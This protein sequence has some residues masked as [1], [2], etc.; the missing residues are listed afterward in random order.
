M[1]RTDAT[2]FVGPR[3]YFTNI[4]HRVLQNQPTAQVRRQIERE[5]KVL[6]LTKH[7]VVCAALHLTGQF[8]YDL[9]RANPVLL[10]KEMIVPALRND[11]NDESWCIW[12]MCATFVWS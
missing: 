5:L 4:D 12:T 1:R 8:A 6:L 7:T 9:F 11:R 10:D 3:A 2:S